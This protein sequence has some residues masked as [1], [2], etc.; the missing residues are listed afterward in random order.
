MRDVR[1]AGGAAAHPVP[2]PRLRELPAFHDRFA[3][4]ADEGPRGV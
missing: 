1:A 2:L 4:A 3:A